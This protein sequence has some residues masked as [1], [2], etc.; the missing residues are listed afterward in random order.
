MVPMEMLEADLETEQHSFES[1]LMSPAS[2][3]GGT[4]A[5]KT[6]RKWLL[7][8]NFLDIRFPITELERYQQCAIMLEEH[9]NLKICQK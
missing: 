1:L 8:R 4:M 5:S 7:M 9:S 3:N 6:N 2:T